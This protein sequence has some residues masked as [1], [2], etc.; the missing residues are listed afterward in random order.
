MTP[1]LA[2][3]DTPGSL[4][5][6]DQQCPGV[7]ASPIPA[8]LSY[9]VPAGPVLALVAHRESAWG[10][11]DEDMREYLGPA[12]SI[13]DARGLLSR[14]K[15]ETI[16]RRLLTSARG[17]PRSAEATGRWLVAERIHPVRP[18]KRERIA[19][20]LA[21]QGGWELMAVDLG[22]LLRSARGER[23]L[24]SVAS[25]LRVTA[26]TVR[27]WEEGFRPHR[28]RRGHRQSGPRGPD[29]HGASDLEPAHPRPDHSVLGAGPRRRRAGRP[30]SGEVPPLCVETH[31]GHVPG[32]AR[33]A[34]P[35]NR[36]DPGAQ[37]PA[38]D[39]DLHAT[40]RPGHP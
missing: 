36:R 40:G 24:Q 31:G 1:A 28:A 29:R 22:T 3:A 13:R 32:R 27:A 4:R 25:L 14:R 12:C 20:E 15:A 35:G 17:T 21:D 30:A 39:V 8:S 16:L 23:S 11:S 26:M 18:A 19:G 10:F 34:A 5:R 2:C 6:P 33:R 38:G 37:R 7:I 9:F